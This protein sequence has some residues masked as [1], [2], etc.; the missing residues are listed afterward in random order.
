[1]PI[2]ITIL[3]TLCC[4]TSPAFADTRAQGQAARPA[5]PPG[6]R[7]AVSQSL[8][9]TL[10]GKHTE[11]IA[12]FE[13]WVAKYPNFLDARMMLGAAHENL[14]RDA[15]TSGAADAAARSVKHFEAAVVHFRRA[16]ELPG[17]DIGAMRVLIDVHG[18]VGLNRPAEYERLVHE[19]LKRFPTEPDAHAYLIALLASKEAP[20]DSAIRAAL[21]AVP[22]GPDSRA[23][24]AGVLYHFGREPYRTG[25]EAVLRA[26]LQFAQEALKINPA[27]ADALREKAR[28]EEELARRDRL[29]KP[30]YRLGIAI[31]KSSAPPDRLP[32]GRVAGRPIVGSSSVWRRCG[33]VQPSI[34]GPF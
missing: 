12:I 29:R 31:E 7:E 19:G 10:A 30:P 26:A 27:H 21:A 32:G 3:A 5:A 2:V 20:L 22:K 1:M 16:M 24:L 28:I 13:K 23:T 17:A 18:P 33:G 9:L 34:D 14:G 4:I 15:L 8:D 11:L 25:A 6:W